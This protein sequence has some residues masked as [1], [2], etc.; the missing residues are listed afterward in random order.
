MTL[1]S[2]TI[3][4][5]LD[6][7]QYLRSTVSHLRFDLDKAGRAQRG[8]TSTADIEPRAADL[9][10]TLASSGP[11]V[12]ACPGVSVNADRYR[13]RPV[14]IEAVQYL[15][16]DA[17]DIVGV[18]V[19]SDGTR[20]IETL[21]GRMT[22]SPGDWVITGLKGERY[23]CKPDVFA[24]SYESAETRAADTRDLVREVERLRLEIER[25]DA[26]FAAHVQSANEMK[27]H[28]VRVSDENAALRLEAE[29][30]RAESENPTGRDSGFWGRTAAR[31]VEKNKALQAKVDESEKKATRY[32][33]MFEGRCLDCNNLLPS[34][35]PDCR[36]VTNRPVR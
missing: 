32:L 14:V 27:E 1:D 10:A 31:L 13:K 7:V 26:A 22:V 36:H 24:A 30:L 9:E 16:P 17:G 19:A 35:A 20:Y 23:P 2:R 4:A 18:S 29:R 34:H 5:I 11:L 15:G 3:I 33:R 8:S 28:A 25:K 12:L 21:E 6:D